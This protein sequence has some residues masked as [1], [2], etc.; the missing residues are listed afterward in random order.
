MFRRTHVPLEEAVC[1][2]VYLILYSSKAHEALR[3][4]IVYQGNKAYTRNLLKSHAFVFIRN[5]KV[6]ILNPPLR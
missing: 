6:V 3:D 1:K 5:M 4:V 2:L